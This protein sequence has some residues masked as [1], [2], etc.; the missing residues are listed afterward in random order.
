MPC[1]CGDLPLY[2]GDNLSPEVY[3]DLLK[4]N[5]AVMS[6]PSGS[7]WWVWAIIG[8]GALYAIMRG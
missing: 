1:P 5:G 2:P 3:K 4:K 7:T 8:V 6:G